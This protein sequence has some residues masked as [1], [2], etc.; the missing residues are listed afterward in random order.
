MQIRHIL[1][2]FTRKPDEPLNVLIQGFDGLF[3]ESLAKTGHTI[4]SIPNAQKYPCH[5]SLLPNVKWIQ[6]VEHLPIGL[7]LDVVICNDRV[8]GYNMCN[9]LASNLHIPL[10]IVEHYHPFG[11]LQ[12]EDIYTLQRTQRCNKHVV[13]HPAIKDVWESGEVIP[14]GI[15]KY[16]G[17]D[18][19]RL[20]VTIGRYNPIELNAIRG[21][22]QVL[23]GHHIINLYTE[24]TSL[25]QISLALA[26]ADTYVGF[27]MHNNIPLELLYAAA[28][29][30]KILTSRVP[31]IEQ[32]FGNTVSYFNNLSELQ[33]SG[34]FLQQLQGGAKELVAELFDEDRFI[35]SWK[36]ILTEVT[37]NGHV[38]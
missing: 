4:W 11:M 21:A 22:M 16:N 10:I 26:A 30:C 5:P 36:Q 29:G 17:V 6:N 3:E 1:R 19:T 37:N 33:K 24:Q 32:T 2:P 23:G 38:R 34:V 8:L 7:T 18:K 20:A 35:Q 25:E 9:A 27:T 12:K 13:T 28:H 15:P 31:L 14:Y